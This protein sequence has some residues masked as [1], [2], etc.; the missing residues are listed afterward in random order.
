MALVRA[1]LNRLPSLTSGNYLPDHEIAQA[2]SIA[3]SVKEDKMDPEILERA[4]AVI[5][6]L[7]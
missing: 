3:Y 4:D 1:F 2:L 5:A 6:A 7:T